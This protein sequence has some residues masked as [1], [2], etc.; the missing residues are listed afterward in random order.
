M[1]KYNK[2]RK[3][4]Y[5]LAQQLLAQVESNIEQNAIKPMQNDIKKHHF[6]EGNTA[7]ELIRILRILEKLST[8]SRKKKDKKNNAISE[9]D[10]KIVERY[11]EINA[12][13]SASE[14]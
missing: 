7:M 14:A 3:R 4:I 6:N 13:E 10:S 11:R 5:A 8:P 1:A 9:A 12:S 2:D